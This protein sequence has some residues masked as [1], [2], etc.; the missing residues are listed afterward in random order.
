[1][2]AQRV[3][4]FDTKGNKVMGILA[5][6]GT[7]KTIVIL[8][9]GFLSG[10]DGAKY[11]A[12]EKSLNAAGTATLRFD[13]YAHNDSEGDFE[14]VTMTRGI[15]D[16][17]HAIDYARAKG[18]ARISMVGCSFGGACAII[19]ASKTSE[20]SAL[21]LIAPVSNYA[22]RDKMVNADALDAWKKQG[23]QMRTFWTGAPVRLNYTF[24][25]DY[26]QYDGYAAAK[27]ITI[28]TLII[29]GDKDEAVPIAQS[30]KT[31]SLL[32]HGKLH[33]IAG[34]D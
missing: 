4:F 13:F 2:T 31:A 7:A 3:T 16:I 32:A 19:A 28:P 17:M 15:D 1:M 24:V 26:Q 30:Q 29:H 21:V 8:A 34:A 23:Y 25:E 18:Y 14:D 9:H 6:P 22:E 10:K 11:I 27:R 12:L 20:L 5:D 33:I